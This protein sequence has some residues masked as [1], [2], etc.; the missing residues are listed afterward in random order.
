MNAAIPD[1]DIVNISDSAMITAAA[2]I[3]M[4]WLASGDENHSTLWRQPGRSPRM[5]R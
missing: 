2:A 1:L 4:S 5:L 3:R